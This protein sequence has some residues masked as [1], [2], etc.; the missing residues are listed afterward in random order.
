MEIHNIWPKHIRCMY[1][2]IVSSC[3]RYMHILVD[4]YTSLLSASP[5]KSRHTSHFWA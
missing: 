3:Y 2:Y 5:D 1:R 4:W